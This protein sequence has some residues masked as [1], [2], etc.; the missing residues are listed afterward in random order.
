MNAVDLRFGPL[1]KARI[2]LDSASIGAAAIERAVRL[3]ATATGS[4]S[5]DAYWQ[6]LHAKPGE[7][8]QLIEAVVVPE[9]WFYRYPES[10]VALVDVV[11]ARLAREP[12]PVRILSLPCSTGEEPYS[13]VMALLDAGIAPSQL[14]VDAMDVSEAV[15][16][17]ARLAVYGPNSFRGEADGWRQRYFTTGA[18][19]DVLSRRVADLVHFQSGNLFDTP[20]PQ[21]TASTYD[22]VFCRNL[23]IYFDTPTQ[24]RAVRLLRQ[25]ARRD[26]MLFVGP[27]EASLLTRQGMRAWRLPHAFAFHV[28]PLPVLAPAPVPSTLNRP[29]ALM[30]RP[31]ALRAP[32]RAATARRWSTLI[33]RDASAPAA[34]SDATGSSDETALAEISR[35]ADRG[36]TTLALA[37]C[38]RWLATRSPTA[39]VFYLQGLLHDAAGRSEAAQMAYRKA[40]YLDPRHRETLAHLAALLASQGDTEGARRLQARGARKERQHG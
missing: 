20:L 18:Q 12:G 30:A 6:L 7:M 3:R 5:E 8:Q 25:L 28:A 4:G 37:A 21:A 22:I 14:A 1:L 35:L 16:A 39:Q 26:G 24:E 19:G 34:A 10:L 2:G 38:E 33:A 36:E 23:L 40:L 31:P 17:R 11:R 15:I 29:A 32:A 13:I 27:A 9:T